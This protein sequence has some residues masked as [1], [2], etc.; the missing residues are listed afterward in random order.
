MKMEKT[1]SE[2]VEQKPTD[3]EL[4]SLMVPPNHGLTLDIL[5]ACALRSYLR[6]PN[7]ACTVVL[8]LHAV[9]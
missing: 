5:H 9:I 2:L 1:K 3:E 8:V 6:L 4:E 7:T